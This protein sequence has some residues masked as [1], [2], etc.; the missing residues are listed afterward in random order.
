MLFSSITFLYLFIPITLILCL[1]APQRF[2]NYVLLAASLIFYAYGEPRYVLLLL[3]SALV[4]WLHGLGFAKRPGSKW[5]LASGLAWSLA[6]L[7]F[8]KYADLLIGSVNSLMGTELPLLK[9][10]LPIGISFYTLQNI[11]YT[12]DA[13]RGRC[14][15]QRSLLS[16]STYLCLFPRLIA[17]PIVPYRDMEG[18]LSGRSVSL[19]DLSEG[20]VRFAVG[21]GKTVL[22]AGSLEPLAILTVEDGSVLLSWLC[23]LAYIFQIYFTLSGCSDIAVGLCRMLGF[24]LPENF[25]YPLLSSSVTQFWQRWHSSLVQW[26]RDYVYLPMGGSATTK[27]K[28]LRNMLVVWLLIGIWHGTGWTFLLWGLYY[29]ILLIL[30]KLWL[31]RYLKGRI[32]PH[33]YM[34]L[35]TVLGFVLFRSGTVSQVLH[36]AAELLGLGGLP[37]I[38]ATAV[39]QLRSFGVLLVMALAGASPYPKKLARKLGESKAGTILQP[40]FVLILVLLVTACLVDNTFDP[41]RYFRF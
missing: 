1:L 29:G 21:L 9:L 5:I 10:H 35:V 20:S 40:C 26:F 33:V 38:N 15:I 41:F 25:D 4:S 2:R 19:D 39:Y 30:E 31:H 28:W 16:Y 23:I 12:V 24:R 11:S 22:L 14:K 18:Q 3:L 7:L 13:Y 34:L 32:L 6:F 8:F 27:A 36:T 37:I 17:G